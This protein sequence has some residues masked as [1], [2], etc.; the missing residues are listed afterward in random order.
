MNARHPQFGRFG[1]RV[2]PR[3][4]L[5]CVVGMFF[6]AALELAAA[7]SPFL[8]RVRRTLSLSD[9]NTRVVFAGVTALGC[10][11]GFAGAF[12]LLRKRS[13]LSDTLSHSTLPGIA[14]AFLVAEG[15]GFSGRSLPWLLCGGAVS[16]VLGMLTVVAIRTRSRVKDDAALAIVL[17]VFFGL[18]IALLVIIQQLP[19]GNAAG[20][21]NEEE[22]MTPVLGK[23][24]R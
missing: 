20:A 2:S 24:T 21:A 6:V 22:S 8:E 4:L 17:S 5:A 7:E 16:G 13:L 1:T 23:V 14:I 3:L 19:T 15:A 11:S 18:G 10:A 9:Y 12:L